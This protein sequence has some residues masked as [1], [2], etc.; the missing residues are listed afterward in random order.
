MDVFIEPIPDS[1]VPRPPFGAGI[2][3]RVTTAAPVG[4]RRERRRERTKRA[5]LDAAL[6]LF[7][8]HGVHGARLEDI[9]GHA[10][11]G[12]GAFYN[13]FPSK[14]ALVA[15]LLAEAVDV[16]AGRYL[17]RVDR[18][19]PLDARVAAIVR[20][21]Y[22][23]FEDHPPYQLLFHQARGLLT[24]RRATPELA[25]VFDHYL[26]LLADLVPEARARRGQG[27]ADQRAA[28][29]LLAGAVEG[30]RSFALAG[31]RLPNSPLVERVLASG[32]ACAL[33]RRAEPVRV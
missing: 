1:S 5:L 19:I 23:F 22:R 9:T 28:A 32:F 3:R 10:D 12:K 30:Y 2:L 29:A 27:P 6:R 14:D 26:S 13:Y 18:R 8:E 4:G 11:L 17:A 7:A 24:L 25:R 21:Y 16:L 20:E 31:G 33:G 15:A